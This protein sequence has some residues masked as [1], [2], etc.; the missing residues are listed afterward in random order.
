M[1][2]VQ[3]GIDSAGSQQLGEF[4]DRPFPLRSPVLIPVGIGVAQLTIAIGTVGVGLRM[5]AVRMSRLTVGGFRNL[6]QHVVHIV[7]T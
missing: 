1:P 2:Q 3:V 6:E 4:F 5:L 7:G